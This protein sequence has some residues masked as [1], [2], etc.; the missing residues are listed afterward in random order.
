[1]FMHIKAPDENVL[2][3][4][5]PEVWW[6][7]QVLYLRGHRFLLSCGPVG[8]CVVV[9]VEILQCNERYTLWHWEKWNMYYFT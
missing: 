3:Q 8:Q 2:A 6:D 4:L 5:I 1:M 9:I 7:T